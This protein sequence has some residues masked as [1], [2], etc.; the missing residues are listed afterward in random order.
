MSR[1]TAEANKAIAAAWEREQQ[2]VNEGKGTRDWTTEQQIDILEKGKAY[3]YD[4]RALEGHH[5]KS[6]A[7]FPEHQGNPDNIQFLSRSEHF[8]AHG[9][10][11]Q[12]PTNGYYN[13]IGGKTIIFTG[14]NLIPCQIII[15]SNPVIDSKKI[16]NID[17]DKV[18][19]TAP[20]ESEIEVDKT[21]NHNKSMNIT[22]QKIELPPKTNKSKKDDKFILQGFRRVKDA[23]RNF[24]TN[25]P[26][27]T[28]VIKTVGPIVAEF[29][30]TYGTSVAMNGFGSKTK[31][32]AS[33][34]TIHSS[35][36]KTSSNSNTI[37]NVASAI[38]KTV[39]KGTHASPIK[40][41]VSGYTKHINGKEIYVSSYVRGGKTNK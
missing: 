11:F 36:T 40:H 17:C 41:T 24:E 1:R 33:H 6:V 16:P 18:A 28:E 22:P 19:E 5:M 38:S 37:E 14:D 23:F 30:I 25:H 27:A 31:T 10:S 29:A 32:S 3:D 34:G 35:S 21:I 15:L 9:G 4:G 2:L 39:E 12:N 26:V 20:M 8:E 13:P 7:V